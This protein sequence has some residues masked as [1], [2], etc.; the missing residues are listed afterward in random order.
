MAIDYP[1]LK[2]RPFADVVQH[3]TA[4]DCILYALGIGL[5]QDPLD[6]AQL[7][8]TYE[9]GL[10]M[11]PTMPV[12]IGY[13]GFW[14]REP[15]TGVRWEGVV[16]GEQRLTI[17]EPLPTDAVVVGRTRVDEI[18]DK[19]P[20]RGALVY[21][22]REIRRQDDDRLLC[23]LQ[24]TAFC[25]FDGGFSG[26][27]PAA[28]APVQ[29]LRPV[30]DRRPDRSFRFKTAPNAALIYRLSGDDNPLHADP[31]VA[32][33]A[34]F[35]RP[36]LHGLC[37]YG[38]AGHAVVTMACGGDAQRLRRLDVR[39]TSPVYPGETL[40]TELW[41]NGDHEAQL[42]CRVVERDV[43]VLDHGLAAWA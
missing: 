40:S 32:R 41:F 43:V 42:R 29:A 23:T 4:R 20:G 19:G 10:Q 18:V 34:G 38:V 39:F 22:S 30:P 13:G 25:R 14:L 16:H 26:G 21:T 9:R 1:R 37:T 35:E 3:Y 6:E 28:K 17:H 7:R 5:G 33:E 11:L 31:A 24:S 36:I 2:A 12:V 8:F 27:E 15:D